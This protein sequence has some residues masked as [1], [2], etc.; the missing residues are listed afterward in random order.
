[1]RAKLLFGSARAL[2]VREEV[3]QD[4][5]ELL[6]GPADAGT[7]FCLTRCSA[8]SVRLQVE[9]AEIFQS[10]GD[11]RPIRQMCSR[12]WLL[13]ILRQPAAQRTEDQSPT[14][15]SEPSH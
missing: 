5:V 14:K 4:D 13:I 8:S 10:A 15:A 2:L 12:T 7:T 6:A 11:V 9:N 1:M 3:V